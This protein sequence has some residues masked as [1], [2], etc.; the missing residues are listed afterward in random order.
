MVKLSEYKKTF[1]RSRLRTFGVKFKKEIVKK[2]ERNEFSVSEVSS[3]Y[4]YSSC[5][6]IYLWVHGSCRLADYTCLKF[7]SYA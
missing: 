1:D 5:K 6:F 2:I 7:Q 3:L 4:L